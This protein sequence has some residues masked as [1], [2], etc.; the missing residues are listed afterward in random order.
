MG[1]IRTKLARIVAVF[2]FGVVLAL[3]PLQGASAVTSGSCQ[4]VSLPVRLAP[5]LPKDQTAVGDLCLPTVWAT[6]ER[7]VDVL[8]HGGSYNRSYWDLPVSYPNYSYVE[9]TLQQGRATFAYDRLG[10]GD[11]SRPLSLLATT[12]ADAYIL[13][14][15]INWLKGH[16]ADLD[17]VN[18]IGHSLGSLAAAKEAATHH[19]VDRLVVTGLLHAVGPA[20]TQFGTASTPAEFDAQFAGQGY[21]LGYLT[22]AP[23]S[24][25]SIFYAGAT[26]A[27]VI[28]YDEAHKDVLASGQLTGMAQLVELPPLNPSYYVTADVLV[29]DGQLDGLFCGILLDCTNTTAV[30]ANEAP[31][32]HNAASLSVQTVANTG[33]NLALHP[34]TSASFSSINEWIE[35]E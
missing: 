13:H 3:T 2:L 29:I 14:Q 19:D 16:S 5:L 31:Y 11:S 18:V 32:Y 7:N 10:N 6:G 25:G 28:A 1:N 21:D 22:T 23:G 20:F 24:R 15:V 33:H 17:E 4:T 30:A 26:D 27:T 12:E 34:S 8:V 35:N 9:R